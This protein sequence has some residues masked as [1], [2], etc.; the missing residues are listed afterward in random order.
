MMSELAPENPFPYETL[1][2]HRGLTEIRELL[3]L[4]NTGGGFIGGGYARYCLSP[5][6]KPSVPSDVDI[7]CKEVGAYQYLID[8]IVRRGGE[9]KFRTPNA[10]TLNPPSYWI[11]CPTIQIISPTLMVGGPWELISKFD[12]TISIAA[13]TWEGQGI[14]HLDFEDHEYKQALIVNN[15]QCPVGTMKRVLKYAKK[16]YKLSAHELLK[17]YS[18]WDGWAPNKKEELAKLIN[19][20]APDRT[21]QDQEDYR[22]L[23]YI[24]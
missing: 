14:A 5:L 1:S 16:G 19:I 6:P 10:V 11:S 2:A 8:E 18:F 22:R 13:L 12:F 23:M 17:F 21:P 4:V 3:S 9:V 15:I 20:P 24:D 7:F